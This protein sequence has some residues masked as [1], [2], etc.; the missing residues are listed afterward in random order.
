M[1]LAR[2]LVTLVLSYGF[3]VEATSTTTQSPR[4]VNT[5]SAQINF[6]RN[7][8]SEGEMGMIDILGLRGKTFAE[9]VAYGRQSASQR[10][11]NLL[12]TDNSNSRYEREF[13]FVGEP[14]FAQIMQ[15]IPS[16]RGVFT[17]EH[18]GVGVML[19]LIERTPV[20]PE[21]V[22]SSLRGSVENAVAVES[23]T[24]TAF[25]VW[26]A[27]EGHRLMHMAS[28]NPPDRRRNL[29]IPLLM[30]ITGLGVPR[31]EIK[32]FAN[33]NGITAF[34]EHYAEDIRTALIYD[35]KLNHHTRKRLDPS[36]ATSTVQR[37]LSH[38][39]YAADLP[40][41]CSSV[42][43]NLEVRLIA[44]VHRYF[45]N[46]IIV[47]SF[48]PKPLELLDV[49]RAR[50][51]TS[52]FSKLNSLS[53][54]LGIARVTF[55]DEIGE[56]RGVLRDWFATAS[57]E[58]FNPENGFYELVNDGGFYQL[59]EEEGVFEPL[60]FYRGIGTFLALSIVEEI[61][62]GINL[63]VYLFD[64]FA[65]RRSTLEKAALDQ[66]VSAMNIQRILEMT[67]DDL[68]NLDLH[69]ESSGERVNI[70]NRHKVAKE[71]LD[72][73]IPTKALAGEA[74]R[75]MRQGFR[76][77]LIEPDFDSV[78]MK[79]AILGSEVID[80]EDLIR[81]MELVGFTAG[82]DQMV[83]LHQTL[84]AWDQPK[85]KKWITFVTGYPT[86][87]INGAAGFNPRITVVRTLGDDSKFPR[88]RTCFNEFHLPV[89]STREILV[90]RI[91]TAIA[92]DSAMGVV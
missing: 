90:S 44:Q 2:H 91:E 27:A 66:R 57:S 45:R 63:P 78:D 89:Y 4:G 8:L 5:N 41:F 69:L 80:P 81:F 26:I 35:H 37:F 46:R 9:L 54:H 76:S 67:E 23:G 10:N 70:K 31:A 88:A 15:S 22:W 53:A 61:P 7:I 18:Y 1:R 87:P 86:V 51:F 29:I 20:V 42:F 17:R 65:D 56:G 79:N 36:T 12:M 68:G 62:L 77:V 14:R 16:A 21:S 19:D 52:L 74:Y 3:G 32:T 43:S 38:A 48:G 82:D 71:W 40:L 13:Y 60:S 47:R 24:P 33:D 85:L 58:L 55:R 30:L 84:R 25:G 75:A 59:N 49:P 39:C 11:L 92:H 64:F 28:T 72:K 73:L 6:L 34:C 50:P 83:W